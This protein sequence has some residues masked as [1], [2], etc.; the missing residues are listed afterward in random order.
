MI[1]EAESG[2][3]GSAAGGRVFVKFSKF[4]I[5]VA[6]LKKPFRSLLPSWA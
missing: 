1:A 5:P 3:T 6:S 2:A 4:Y